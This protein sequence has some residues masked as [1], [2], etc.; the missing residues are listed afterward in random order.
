MDY[1]TCDS[2]NTGV[3][4]SVE[5]RNLVYQ[6]IWIV[7]LM[8]LVWPLA[9][10]ISPVWIVLLALEAFIPQGATLPSHGTMLC[11]GD[12]K[13]CSAVAKLNFSDIL[14]PFLSDAYVF[15]SPFHRWYQKVKEINDFLEKLLT[16]PR[17]MGFAI[18]DG[19]ESFPNPLN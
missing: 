12:F 6:I 1:G 13:H 11:S 18:R 7:F 19:R 14:T 15:P 10:T 9:W 17:T 3:L 2:A 8:V 16:W 5:K 4:S